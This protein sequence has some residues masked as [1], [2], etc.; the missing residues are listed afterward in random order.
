VIKKKFK[1][2]KDFSVEAGNR[3]RNS[4]LRLHLAGDGAEGNTGISAR[5]TGV[6]ADRCSYRR[7]ASLM[8]A[9][10]CYLEGMASGDSCIVSSKK[11][12]KKGVPVLSGTKI[13]WL[14]SCSLLRQN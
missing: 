8:L 10:M 1:G 6:C 2:H 4:D 7:S 11:E 14:C 9:R 13:L 5:N 3:N 12:A